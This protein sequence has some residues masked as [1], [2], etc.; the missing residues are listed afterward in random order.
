MQTDPTQKSKVPEIIVDG[1]KNGFLADSDLVER[2]NSFLN[3]SA[4]L[5]V[6]P[7]RIVS[8]HKSFIF[9]QNHFLLLPFEKKIKNFVEFGLTD[10]LIKDYEDSHRFWIERDAEDGPT[11]LTLDHL[12][13]GFQICLLFLLLSSLSF[14]YEIAV[15]AVRKISQMNPP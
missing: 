3:S 4:K 10:K 13:V 12:G 15:E 6:L 11:V 14:C 9:D 5:K 2:Y 1:L 7:E 8:N